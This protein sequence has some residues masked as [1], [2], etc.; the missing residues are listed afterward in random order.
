VKTENAITD[1]IIVWRRPMMS[2]TVPTAMA[3][4]MTPRSPTTEIVVAPA[5]VSPHS[6]SGLM[7]SGITTPRTTRS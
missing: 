3:P 5:A 2:V 7:S 4:T 1:Q 6:L